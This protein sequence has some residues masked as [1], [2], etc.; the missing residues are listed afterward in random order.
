MSKLVLD[1]QNL[2]KEIQEKRYNIFTRLKVAASP[3]KLKNKR[4]Y[5]NTKS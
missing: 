2:L 1:R 4:Y 3:G 5:K